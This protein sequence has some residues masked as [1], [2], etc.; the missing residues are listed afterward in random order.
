MVQSLGCSDEMLAHYHCMKVTKKFIIDGNVDKYPWNRATWSPRFVD[1]VTGVPGF[2]D[3]RCALLWD[4]SHLY[5][6][7]RIQEPNIQAEMTQR[8]ERVYLENDVE[9]FIAGDDCY[10]E[11]QINALG[12]VYEVF[13][14]WQQAYTKGSRFDVPEFDLLN[15]SVDVLGGFQDSSRYEKHPRGKRW[16]FMDWDFPELKTAVKLDGNLNDSSKVDKEWTVE[17]AFPWKGMEGLFNPGTLPLH[18]GD[19]L[20]MDLSRFEKLSFNGHTP[21]IHPGWSLNA[22]G[23]YDSHIPEC[24]SV[25]HLS[26]EE[27]E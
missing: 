26:G 10:Y 8:D 18:A 1:M 12:T 22:H 17:T 3:T 24:F 16:A 7:F 15:R 2:L 4:D 23:V 14:I 25:I 13:Y 20:R 19:C 6:A 5:V 21:D 27:I 9:I 11:F